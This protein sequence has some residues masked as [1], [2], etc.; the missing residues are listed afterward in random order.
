MQVVIKGNTCMIVSKRWIHFYPPGS[1]V[2]HWSWFGDCLAMA[3]KSDTLV[4]SCKNA[5]LVHT[6]EWDEFLAQ[7]Q[8]QNLIPGVPIEPYSKRWKP[9]MT[10][11][12]PC[13]IDKR[14]SG[15]LEYLVYKPK[16]WI[17]LAIFRVVESP[18]QIWTR[19][20]ANHIQTAE[21]DAL[22]MREVNS[23]SIFENNSSLL[24]SLD[25]GC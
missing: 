10:T 4:S 16:Y 9:P 18:K 6:L 5:F 3:I 14:A 21:G 25:M 15:E 1:V 12:N 2:C 13:S 19:V 24:V 7:F 11:K 22:Q 23:V 17:P 20:L 8:D